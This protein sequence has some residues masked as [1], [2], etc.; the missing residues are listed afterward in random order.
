VAPL[1]GNHTFPFAGAWLAPDLCSPTVAW[2][3]LTVLIVCCMKAK[4]GSLTRGGFTL[5]ELMIVVAII[6]LLTTLA[7]PNFAR[8]RDNSRLS[9]I[10]ANLR[11]LEAAKDT[12]ALENNKTTGTS[13]P[14]IGI[15]SNYFRFGTIHDVVHETYVPNAIGTRAQANLPPGVSLG[16]FGP[17]GAIPSP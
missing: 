4:L 2:D 15:L 5:T 12:W 10:Y 7:A 8:A 3:L 1:H 11:V 17:G 16:P 6:A 14:D 9:T 13:V